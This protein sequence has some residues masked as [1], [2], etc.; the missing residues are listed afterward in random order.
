MSTPNN[1]PQDTPEPLK[2]PQCG[3]SWI[4]SPIPEKDREHF[5]NAT[6]FKREIGVEIQGKYD[7][8]DHWLCPDCGATFDRSYRH[9]PQPERTE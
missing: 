4:D 1:P 5:G 3:A 8:A 6:H 9:I 7:G 2:C